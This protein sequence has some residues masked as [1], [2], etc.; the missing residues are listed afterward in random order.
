MD[1]GEGLILLLILVAG[2]YIFLYSKEIFLL[3]RK[4]YS[5]EV[6]TYCSF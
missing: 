5:G 4:E 1:F 2:S 6:A 3:S